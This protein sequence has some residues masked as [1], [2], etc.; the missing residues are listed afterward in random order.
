MGRLRTRY[1]DIKVQA[2]YSGETGNIHGMLGEV[3]DAMRRARC[4]ATEIDELQHRVLA[5]GD[6]DE[7]VQILKETVSLTV[8]R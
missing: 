5:A 8:L 6:Y 3:Q 1:P 4:P 7:A 2:E